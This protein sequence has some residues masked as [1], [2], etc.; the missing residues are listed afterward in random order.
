MYNEE[1]V[2]PLLVTRLRPVLD[3]L[4]EAYEIVAVDDASSDATGQL[5]MVLRHH[6]PQLRVIR[7]LRNSGHQAALMAGLHR[8]LGDHV[9]SLDADLQHPPEKIHDMLALARTER[10]DVVYGVRLDRSVDTAARRFA[11]RLYHWSARRVTGTGVPDR[12]GDFRLLSRAIV[13]VLKALPEHQP[14]YRLLVPWIGFP[15]G[16][17]TYRREARA[18][19]RTKYRL[20]RKVRLTYDSV[21]SFSAAPLRLATWLGGLT[22][23]LCLGLIAMA[24]GAY[25]TGYTVPGWTSLF[26]AVMLLGGV[27]MLCTGLL[28]EYVGRIYSTLQ[29]RPAYLVAYDSATGAGASAAAGAGAE[30]P[31]CPPAGAAAGEPTRNDDEPPAQADGAGPASGVALGSGAAP[32]SGGAGGGGGEA[33]AGPSGGRG[34]GVVPRPRVP[35]D[36]APG[37][38]P[39]G[40]VRLAPIRA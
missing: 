9:V 26:A 34:G 7:L 29:R 30:P 4:G 19:G 20:L 10:L 18:A 35:Q 25:A 22:V 28:G 15:S 32:G 23:L 39:A 2:L 31:A 36:S 27:Q 17:V 33:G 24:V 3:G 5:L 8:A 11:R 12:F 1:E 6:W 13:E 40:G 38:G 16:E 14:V 37:G 21:T